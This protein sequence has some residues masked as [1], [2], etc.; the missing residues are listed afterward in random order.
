MS[1]LRCRVW[2]SVA[3]SAL[4]RSAGPRPRLAPDANTLLL[5]RVAFLATCV[6]RCRAKF[7]GAAL[8]A[9]Q[10]AV[11]TTEGTVCTTQGTVCTTQGTCG[12]CGLQVTGGHLM[13]YSSVE[14]SNLPQDMYR[15]FKQVTPFHLPY[16]LRH[17]VSRP[18]PNALV[19]LLVCLPFLAAKPHRESS[20]TLLLSPDSVSTS[21]PQLQ[22]QQPDY[23]RM[24]LLAHA[25]MPKR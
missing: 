10:S 14:D 1:C 2:R 24:L 20:S 23:H 21:R 8:R 9:R 15:A 12:F 7:G 5:G 4:L 6:C 13:L 22:L 16:C 3:S 17:T 19:A 25:H 11:C 18:T